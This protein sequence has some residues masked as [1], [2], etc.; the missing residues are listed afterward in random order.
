VHKPVLFYG[1]LSSNNLTN[2]DSNPW[3]DENGYGL[4]IKNA[5]TTFN[6]QYDIPSFVIPLGA[7]PL[8]S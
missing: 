3:I 7:S 4:L 6:Y 8:G 2:A 5:A 1:G